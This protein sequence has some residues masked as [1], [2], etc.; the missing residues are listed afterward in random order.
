MAKN[1][2]NFTK[3]AID[4]L[5]LPKEGQRIEF[6]DSK[7]NHL[8][9]RISSTGRKTFQ[10]YR[11]YDGKPSRVTIGTYP[12]LTVEQVRKEAERLNADFAKGEN[13]AD[14]K[15]HQ[16]QEMTFGELFAEYMER[17]AKAK[18]RS[19]QADQKA[20][21]RH[22][23]ALG[24][25]KLSAISRKDIAAIHSAIG[26]DHKTAANRILA[27]VSSVFGRAFEFGLWEGLNPCLGVKRFPEQSRDRF[28]SGDELGRFFEAL[29]Q[30]PNATARDFFLVAL[31]T[32][33]RRSNVLAMRWSEIDLKGA[34]WKIKETKNGLPQTVPLTEE[35][36]EILKDRRKSTA[37]S[38][39]FPGRG[40]TGHYVEPKKAWS[41]ICKAAGIDDIRIHDMRRTLGSWQAITGSSLPIIGKSLGHKSQ[42]A[43]AIYSRLD[44]DPV[45]ASVEKATAAM[46]KAAN[47][48]EVNRLSPLAFNT[49]K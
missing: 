31:L 11:W 47:N 29:R 46:M 17:H 5:P 36:L 7:V 25:K 37:S 24:T 27:L 13:P 26:K 9:V 20:F 16:R 40:C 45:R 2:I 15:R 44:L 21:D 32:G 34:T 3:A 8:L 22:L 35:V 23:S 4:S 14:K 42:Q 43:T 12:D 30:E 19:W 48:G 49:K 6:Y 33:A 39:V 1:V 41:K 10:V 28:L 18:K 38:F